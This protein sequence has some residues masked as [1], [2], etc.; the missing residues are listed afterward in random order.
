MESAKKAARGFLDDRPEPEPPAFVDGAIE[1]RAT[2]GLLD[3]VT[4]VSG[5][6]DAL[7]GQVDGY[8]AIMAYL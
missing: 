3:G 8:L 6:L 4:T 5:A 7:V 2:P 1:V